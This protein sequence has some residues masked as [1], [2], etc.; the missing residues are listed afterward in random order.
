MEQLDTTE[1]RPV[2]DIWKSSPVVRP[3][4]SCTAC[5]D[6]LAVP[7]LNKKF[8]EK[9]GH[10]CGGCAIYEQRPQTCRQYRCLWTMGFGKPSDRPDRIGALTDV[11]DGRLGVRAYA[12]IFA[13]NGRTMRGLERISRALGH[14][15]Y[16]AG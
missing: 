7:E 5:C 3:C 4:G 12:L 6:H 9:C 15:I 8:A 1:S 14:D 11:R 10:S 2:E 13:R 16:V